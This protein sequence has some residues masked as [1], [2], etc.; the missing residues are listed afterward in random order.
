MRLRS[1]NDPPVQTVHPV[2]QGQTPHLARRPVS[3]VG[4][5]ARQ[6]YRSTLVKTNCWKGV[7]WW[8]SQPR[9]R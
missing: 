6:E 1:E 5:A 2:G 7:A 9:L 8:R 3:E 4:F